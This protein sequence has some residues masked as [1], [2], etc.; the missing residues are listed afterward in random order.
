MKYF[1]RKKQE[2]LYEQWA[3]HSE[4]PPEAI[5][6]EESPKDVPVAKEKDRRSLRTLYILLGVFIIIVCVGLGL[7]LVQSC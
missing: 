5:P 3:E 7:L 6:S 4:L 2:K 1:Q